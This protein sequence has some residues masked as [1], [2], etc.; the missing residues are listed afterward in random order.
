MPAVC[1]KFARP[2]KMVLHDRLEPEGRGRDVAHPEVVAGQG[3]KGAERAQRRPVER[4][5]TTIEDRRGCAR[6]IG[7][8]EPRL[9]RPVERHPGPDIEIIRRRRGSGGLRGGRR[10]SR[11]HHHGCDHQGAELNDLPSQSRVLMPHR[12]SLS[13]TPRGIWPR[14]RHPQHSMAGGSSQAGDRLLF[15]R[16][17][18]G[19]TPPPESSC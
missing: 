13:H 10:R 9:F 19:C 17:F 18:G 12:T 14:P 2:S 15:H 16:R 7:V 4:R 3:S 6:T 11:C 5:P 1:T 8:R